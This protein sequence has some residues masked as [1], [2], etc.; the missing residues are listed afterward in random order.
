MAELGEFGLMKYFLKTKDQVYYT[1][2][3]FLRLL[4][5]FIFYENDKA[6]FRLNLNNHIR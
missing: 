1:V 6:I 2:S 3:F 5:T 4:L